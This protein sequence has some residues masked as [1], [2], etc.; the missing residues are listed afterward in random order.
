MSSGP[1]EISADMVYAD[2]DE[3]RKHPQLVAVLKGK[4]GLE[5][6]QLI[7]GDYAFATWNNLWVGLEYK[8][9]ENLMSSLV[10][11]ELTAQLRAMTACC[12]IP[13]LLLE[14][15]RSSDYRGHIRTEHR[16][17]DL[18]WSYVENY[19]AEIQETGIRLAHSPNVGLTA[20]TIQNLYEFW[21]NPDHRALRQVKTDAF[22]EY[23]RPIRRLS[24][25]ADFGPERSHYLLSHFKTLRRVLLASPQER[26][27]VKGI[28]PKLAKALDKELDE[29][30][31]G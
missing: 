20:V 19:L 7:A 10:S 15:W 26:M 16:V 18:P 1:R 28:G 5:E 11:N 23:P 6:K 2:G 25:F 22:R 17:Y 27:A 31:S 14:G 21:Q 9:W 24:A 4:P 13:Y 3:C 8:L 30:Y 29:M 12:D